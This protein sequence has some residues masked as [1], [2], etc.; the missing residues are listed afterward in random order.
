MNIECQAP[1]MDMGALFPA[2]V[3]IFPLCFVTN[4]DDIRFSSVGVRETSLIV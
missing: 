1:K 2:K 4:R 3:I